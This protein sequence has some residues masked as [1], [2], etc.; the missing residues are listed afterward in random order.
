MV[1]VSIV[2]G[3]LH[4]VEFGKQTLII[5]THEIAEIESLLDEVVVL[6]NGE[7]VAKQ[8]VEEIRANNGLSVKEWMVSNFDE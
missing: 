4:Y 3:L 8:N 7:F 1:R 6:K 5:A 2:K